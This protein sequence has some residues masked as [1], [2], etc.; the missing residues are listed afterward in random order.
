MDSKWNKDNFT[1]LLLPFCCQCCDKKKSY[2]TCKRNC[3]KLYHYK[4]H[5]S[6]KD[7]SVWESQTWKED[8]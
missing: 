7:W 4:K 3:G 1:K 5:E 6:Q 2:S 8:K